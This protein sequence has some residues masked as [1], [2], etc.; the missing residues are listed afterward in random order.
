VRKLASVLI[1]EEFHL[2]KPGDESGAYAAQL[3]ALG[4]MGLDYAHPTYV[5]VRR[6]MLAAIARERPN[7]ALL[8]RRAP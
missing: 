7:R 5:E 1:H 4:A 8:A 6:S 2:K 3:T